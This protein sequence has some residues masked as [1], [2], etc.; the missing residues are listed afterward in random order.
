MRP[1]GVRP[2]ERKPAAAR[3]RTAVGI[4]GATSEQAQFSAEEV[5]ERH[6]RRF[7]AGGLSNPE[8]NGGAVTIGLILFGAAL[9]TALV[10]F[11]LVAHTA[12]KD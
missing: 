2:A 12:R 10:L 9:A 7:A 1:A 5:D 3:G 8:R 4:Q 11:L 6:G